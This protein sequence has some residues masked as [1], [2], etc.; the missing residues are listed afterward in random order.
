LEDVLEF[1]LDLFYRLGKNCSK[2]GALLLRFLVPV[3]HTIRPSRGSTAQC[4][5]DRITDSLIPAQDASENSADAGT[6]NR[7]HDSLGDL[8]ALPVNRIDYLDIL[9]LNRKIEFSGLTCMFYVHL[10]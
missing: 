4:S 8:L 7:S 10:G 1:V 5:C 9:A 3:I 6:G 2:I